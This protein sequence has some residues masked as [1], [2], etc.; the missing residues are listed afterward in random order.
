MSTGQD[1]YGHAFCINYDRSN[2]FDL[3]MCGVCESTSGLYTC[4]KNRLNY[5]L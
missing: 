1:E 3:V 5:K 4:L 2:R